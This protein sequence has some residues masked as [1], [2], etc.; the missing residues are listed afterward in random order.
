MTTS[1]I[2][3]KVRH[4]KAGDRIRIVTPLVFIRCGYPLNMDI[5]RKR[6]EQEQGPEIEAFLRKLGFR[7]EDSRTGH[8]VRREI[9][10]AL[11]YGYL[12]RQNFGG[13]MREIYMQEVPEL[14]GKETT[15]MGHFYCKTGEYS[16]AYVS[17]SPNSYGEAYPACLYNEKAH[18]ILE[19]ELHD[20][21]AF[22]LDRPRFNYA[23][24]DIYVERVE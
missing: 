4:I 6:V 2:T 13:R 18:R 14:L 19:T 1:T 11:A 8:R 22:E 15:V 20:P 3:T 21:D 23:I 7:H 10:K 17:T 5:M 12:H 16:P 24:E 9:I